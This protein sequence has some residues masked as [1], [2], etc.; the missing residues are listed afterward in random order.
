MTWPSGPTYSDSA[1]YPWPPPHQQFHNGDQQIARYQPNNFTGTRKYILQEYAPNWVASFEEC[2]NDTDATLQS[3]IRESEETDDSELNSISTRNLKAMYRVVLEAIENADAGDEEASIHATLLS[4]LDGLMRLDMNDRRSPGYP[5]RS[6]HRFRVYAE[7]SKSIYSRIVAS[8]LHGFFLRNSEA[9]LA[10]DDTL[11]LAQWCFAVTNSAMTPGEQHACL[12]LV[13][14]ERPD[15]LDVIQQ[16]RS[17]SR[18]ARILLPALQ[19][20]HRYINTAGSRRGLEWVPSPSGWDVVTTDRRRSLSRGR[21]SPDTMHSPRSSGGLPRFHS[22]D[23]Q[24]R[25]PRD[26]WQNSWPEDRR[27]RR[28]RREVIND[29]AEQVV[30]LARRTGHNDSRDGWHKVDYGVWDSDDD[31][32]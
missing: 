18:K 3:L 20:S 31:S 13:L 9:I 19:R 29:I 14:Q 25:R 8:V 5:R 26:T 24:Q 23:R 28:R 1:V 10:G 6:Q 2:G 27:D 12:S 16:R 11:A 4:D 32:W 22:E 30:D 15:L 21:P 17:S 7:I